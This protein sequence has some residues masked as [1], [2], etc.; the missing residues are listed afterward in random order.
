MDTNAGSSR[1]APAPKN[2]A[3]WAALAMFAAGLVAVLYVFLAASSKPDAAAGLARFARGEMANLVVL[4]SPPPM[5]TRTLRDASG[6][7]TNLQAF[8]GEILVV[9][10]WATWCVWCVDEMPTLAALQRRFEGRLRVLPISFDR[11]ADIEHSK[12]ELARLTDN[13]LPFLIDPSRG[14]MFDT[15]L[16]GM[17]TT[18]FYDPQGREIARFV[19]DADWGGEEAAALMEALIAEHG[20]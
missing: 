16:T 4:E 6:A 7:E 18:I 8:T 12:R 9:N 10:M 5:P 1:G 15:Q 17:P 13:T 2:W 3:W 19:G 20:G 11:E 14:V